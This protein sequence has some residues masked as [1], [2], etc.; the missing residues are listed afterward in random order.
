MKTPLQCN[1]PSQLVFYPSN[2]STRTG[3]VYP[4]LFV[5]RKSSTSSL[6][7][8]FFRIHVIPEIHFNDRNFY[9]PPVNSSLRSFEL[10]LISYRGPIVGRSSVLRV[11]K[12]VVELT[13]TITS[14]GVF[15]IH[16]RLG[17]TVNWKLWDL[18]L[19]S[20]RE[21]LK[22]VCFDIR[23]FTHNKFRRFKHY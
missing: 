14:E 18:S 5:F 4:W 22:T 7:S 15:G 13:R 11:V 9:L 19:E 20:I 23:L 8:V 17:P 6:P 3:L 2:K 21:D 16:S 1:I 12:M 10:I